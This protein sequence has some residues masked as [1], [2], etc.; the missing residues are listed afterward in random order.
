METQNGGIFAIELDTIRAKRLHFERLR[1][2]SQAGA[3]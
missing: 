2:L 3:Q 1:L